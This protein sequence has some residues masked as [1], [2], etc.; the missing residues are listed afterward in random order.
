MST[1]RVMS[2]DASLQAPSASE[3]QERYK[4]QQH[5]RRPGRSRILWLLAGA[6]VL[7]LGVVGSSRLLM[8]KMPPVMDIEY[9]RDLPTIELLGRWATYGVCSYSSLTQLGL[10]TL[11]GLQAVG[12]EKVAHILLRFTLATTFVGGEDDAHVIRTGRL[13]AL[14]NIG[15][16]VDYATEEVESSFEE[17]FEKSADSIRVAAQIGAGSFVA[18]KLT[19]FCPSVTLKKLSQVCV[20]SGTSYPDTIAAVGLEDVIDAGGLT[21]EDIATLREGCTRLEK[22]IKL[23]RQK[24]VRIMLDAES[25]STQLGVDSVFM[26]AQRNE[27]SSAESPAIYQTFQCYTRSAQA[28]LAATIIDA[29]RFGYSFGAKLVRGAYLE[30]ET[31]RATALGVS[32]PLWSTKEETDQCYDACVVDSVKELSRSFDPSTP[33]DGVQG[34]ILCTHNSPSI[35]KGLSLQQCLPSNQ[36]S[37]ILFAQLYGMADQQ[38]H[39]LSKIKDQTKEGENPIVF[40]YVPYGSLEVVTPYLLRRAQENSSI[41]TAAKKE[42]GMIGREVERRLMSGSDKVGEK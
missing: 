23:A 16:I 38:T 12:L 36:Q 20:A 8:E 2:S 13:L 32:S 25:W 18:I 35:E 40:K 28:R 17:E 5:R 22:L 19:S 3:E 42:F 34:L 15:T 41:T 27:S 30:S 11:Q 24:D 21:T 10:L 29:Q 6:P 4:Q 33:T 9:L 31:S 1:S 39:I 7:L 37:K 26:Q 14:K